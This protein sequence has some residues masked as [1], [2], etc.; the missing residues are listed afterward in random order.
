MKKQ[1]MHIDDYIESA[2][3]EVRGVLEEIRRVVRLAVPSAQE[4]ISYQMPALK[5]DKVFFYFAAFKKHIGVY[6]P[7]KGDCQLQ[8]ELERYRGEKGNLRFP[9]AE[10]IPYDLIGRVAS[11]L[12]RQSSKIDAR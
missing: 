7:V 4:T 8:S 12:S 9:L 5:L 6:P 2:S 1:F 11:E 10:P 3:P